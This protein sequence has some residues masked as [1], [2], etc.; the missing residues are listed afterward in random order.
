MCLQFSVVYCREDE[1]MI[2]RVIEVLSKVK[3]L[4]GS[5]ECYVLSGVIGDDFLWFGK[6]LFCLFI[7]IIIMVII[8]VIIVYYM[9]LLI[10]QC[11]QLVLECD[12]LDIEWCN[13]IFEENVFGDY[14]WVEW[15]VI[16]KL[17]M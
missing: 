1:C 14:S 6:L 13:L 10:V 4:I 2:G 16:E 3:G 17:Q 9:C 11:E 12:V 5:N 15:I 8:V 7:C